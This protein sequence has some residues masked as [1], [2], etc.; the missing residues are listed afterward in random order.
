MPELC[1]TRSMAAAVAMGLATMRS[2]SV[3]ARLEVMLIG[4]RSWRSAMKVKSTTDSSAPCDRQPKS[5]SSRK[6]KLSS[7]HSRRG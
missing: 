7:F 5:S 3:K 6:S 4:L 2:Y 1:T